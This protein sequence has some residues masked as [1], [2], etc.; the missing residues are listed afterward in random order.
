MPSNRLWQVKTM[1]QFDSAHNGMGPMDLCDFPRE[2]PCAMPRLLL[3]RHAEAAVQASDGDSDRPLTLQGRTNAK[4]VGI[5]LGASGLI[6][7]RAISS[8]A[9][10]ARDTLD[11]I[12]RELPPVS[13]S[14]ELDDTLYYADAETLIEV[15]AQTSGAVKTL[16]IVGHNPGVG[17]FARFLVR[18]ESALP[19]HFS[20]PCLAVIDVLCNDWREA[21]AGCGRL[22]HFKDF[23]SLRADDS[24]SRT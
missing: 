1:A 20:A 13:A 4:R 11:A 23:A 3:V 19:K 24:I 5:Y 8:P 22:D 15:L 18:P 17:E 21:G 16:L 10:R 6:P 12:L 14:Y 9:L 2:L 7:N